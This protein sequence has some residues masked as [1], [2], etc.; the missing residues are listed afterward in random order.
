[1]KSV[2]GPI[3]D[4][5]VVSLTPAQNHTFMEVYHEIISTVIILLPLIQEVKVCALSMLLVNRLK[6]KIVQKKSLV[7]FTDRPDIRIVVELDVKPQTKN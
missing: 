1:M 5:G 3:T 4:P 6:S 7:R 2:V